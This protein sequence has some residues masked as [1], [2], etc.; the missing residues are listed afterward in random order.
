VAEKWLGVDTPTRPT[1]PPGLRGQ[2][3]GAVLMQNVEIP[4]WPGN[5]RPTQTPPDRK[6]DE[7]AVIPPKPEYMQRAAD[8]QAS[9]EPAV[10]TTQDLMN[11]LSPTDRKH[12]DQA[13]LIGQRLGLPQDQAENLAMATTARIKEDPLIQHADRMVVMQGRG[14]N[15]GDRIYA[16]FHPHG[17][18]EPI[19]N[20]FIDVDRA[21][22][23]PALESAKKIETI[24]LTQTQEQQRQQAL[25]QSQDGQARE[26][27]M[28]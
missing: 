3:E 24:A 11:G 5:E 22:Q 19:F 13:H 28:G 21:A 14:E 9:A 25:A 17:D 16:S 26:L 6:P 7:R 8:P 2:R 15:G 4:A 20:T 27:R 1:D 23:T 18:K 12:Y 10:R